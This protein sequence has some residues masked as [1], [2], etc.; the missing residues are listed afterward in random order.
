[1]RL[2]VDG[3]TLT[4]PV[5]LKPDPRNIPEGG[6]SSAFSANDNQ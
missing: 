2:T 4:R 3:E 6:E 1:V 5:T